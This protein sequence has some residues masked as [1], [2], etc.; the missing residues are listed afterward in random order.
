KRDWSSD[1]C[2]SD[3]E[4]RPFVRGSSAMATDIGRIP[5]SGRTDRRSL[6]LEEI[7]ESTYVSPGLTGTSGSPEVGLETRIIG[8]NI[9][10][11]L[12]GTSPLNRSTTLTVARPSGWTISTKDRK[13]TRL[14]SSHALH[15][16]LPI[17][18]EQTGDR[19]LL[20]K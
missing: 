18:A 10:S 1:V 8:G 6:S 12:S 3:L 11:T 19:F 7:V 5:E 13:S 14:N 16:A 9:T 20:K 4:I 17:L 15:D 2:S